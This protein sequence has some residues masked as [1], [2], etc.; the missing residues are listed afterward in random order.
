MPFWVPQS[1]FRLWGCPININIQA[2][3]IPSMDL[4]PW[5][6]SLPDPIVQGRS[7]WLIHWY[8]WYCCFW[9][10]R[11]L[12]YSILSIRWCLLRAGNWFLTAPVAG[13]APNP[14]KIVYARHFG[15]PT[16]L[17]SLPWAGGKKQGRYDYANKQYCAYDRVLFHHII[18]AFL[19]DRSILLL[20]AMAGSVNAHVIIKYNMCQYNPF[21]I[22]IINPLL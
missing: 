7:V 13:K 18:L 17:F 1:E 21:L 12:V 4:Y 2:W 15:I 19:Q 5:S 22:A 6:G 11:W 20:R 10:L 9:N 14:V 16:H 8:R 3:S